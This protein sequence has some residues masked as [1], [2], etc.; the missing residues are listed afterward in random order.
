MAALCGGNDGQRHTR[1][2]VGIEEEYLLV[3][4][5]SRDLCSRPKE[6]MIAQMQ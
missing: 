3:E 5:D 2:S 1:F 4:R 6:A